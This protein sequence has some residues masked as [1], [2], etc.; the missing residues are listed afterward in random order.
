MRGRMQSQLRLVEM[1]QQILGNLDRVIATL[2]AERDE[3]EVTAD[4]G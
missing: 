4:A 3:P 1:N 2:D